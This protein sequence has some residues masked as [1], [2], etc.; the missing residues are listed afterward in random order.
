MR[1]KILQPGEE[2]TERGLKR[3]QNLASTPVG[4]GHDNYLQGII[5][6][7]DIYAPL[8]MW[9]QIQRYHWIDFI[10]SMSTMHCITKFNIKKQCNKYVWKSTINR[11]NLLISRYNE[12]RDK[13]VWY[14]IISNVPSGFI[15]GASLTTNYRQLKTIY[16]QRKNHRLNEWRELCEWIKTL[17]HSELII[18]DRNGEEK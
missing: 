2:D 11:L 4:E 3:A 1:T 10:S 16:N 17:P 18:N 12:N 6:Q 14:E 15:L 8:Y 9:K 13:E 7:F 5:V